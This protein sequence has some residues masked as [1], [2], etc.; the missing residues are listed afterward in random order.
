MEDNQT[1]ILGRVSGRVQ[2]VFYRASFEHEARARGL[3][4]WVRNLRDG[5]VEFHVQ[6]SHEAVEEIIDW[7]WKGPAGARVTGV[8]TQA[9]TADPELTRFEIRY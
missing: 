1:A 6:G 4:G 3:T 9:S 7:A 2:G 8:D 5:S